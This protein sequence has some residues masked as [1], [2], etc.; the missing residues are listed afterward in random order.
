M[1]NW[2]T[3][4]R[5]YWRT[6]WRGYW[7]TA[8]SRAQHRPCVQHRRVAPRAA[9]PLLVPCQR[10]AARS[11][12]ER[13][14][15]N[16][17]YNHRAGRKDLT[18]R[19]RRRNRKGR[20]ETAT[21]QR[22]ARP[23]PR[24]QTPT[25]KRCIKPLLRYKSICPPRTVC[26]VSDLSVTCQ[27]RST[28]AESS[29][30]HTLRRPKTSS[31]SARASSGS[32]HSRRQYVADPSCQH[33]VF[34]R[35]ARPNHTSE[36]PCPVS[37]KRPAS[38][39]A[40]RTCWRNP[41]IRSAAAARAWRHLRCCGD[42]GSSPTSLL[43]RAFASA[44]RPVLVSPSKSIPL[45]RKSRSSPADRSASSCGR[46]WRVVH[47]PC[48]NPKCSARSE[49]NTP[50]SSRSLWRSARSTAAR[51]WASETGS[52]RRS[53]PGSASRRPRGTSDRSLP[54]R[55]CASP[56]LGIVPLLCS[57]WPRKEQAQTSTT[58]SP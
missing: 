9:R 55:C 45:R 54:L 37:G 14:E 12:G 7:Q 41:S 31:T 18:L 27:S 36:S 48:T 5:T 39:K 1:L 56:V 29:H 43:R 23:T 19:H 3:K 34:K 25:L 22:A 10:K 58:A 26:C 28:V 47:P 2:R 49:R 17:P 16:H 8:S 50:S 20:S 44:R 53:S 13:H 4:W 11:W 42:S 24:M 51:T 33:S 32:G 30:C 15:H 40:A 57:A 46:N 21:G 6:N 38:S 35:P 52:N